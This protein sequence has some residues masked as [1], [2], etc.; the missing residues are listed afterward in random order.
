M[1][2]RKS[3]RDF[4]LIFFFFFFFG[5]GGSGWDWGEGLLFVLF[6]CCFLSAFLFVESFVVVAKGLLLFLFV[7][8]FWLGEG[9]VFQF[10]FSVC[11][12]VCVLRW[13]MGVTD[14]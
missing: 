1:C 13:W 7:I 6:V 2:D 10:I 14:I 9:V 11:V 12:C 5:G 3:E 4:D 8:L